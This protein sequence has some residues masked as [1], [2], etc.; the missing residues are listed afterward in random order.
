MA[1]FMDMLNQ[2]LG[3]VT[4]TPLGQLGTQLLM[5][6]GPQ[7]G[8]PSAVNR[9]GQ[10]LGGMGQMQADQQQLAQTQQLRQFQQM[11]MARQ[12]RQMETEDKQRE[13]VQRLAKEDPTFLA[14][15]P[16]ARALLETTGDTG[17]AAELAKLNPQ[18]KQPNMKQTYDQ[19]NPDGTVTQ[20]VYNY[21]TGRYDA[22]ATYRPTAQQNADI[23]AGRF[24][25]DQEYRPQEFDLKKQNAQTVQAN[26]M[27]NQ[28][29]VEL[30]Q[31][32]EQREQATNLRK[33]NIEY[34]QLRQGYTG[35]TTQIDETIADADR[36]LNHP[37]F[38]SLFGPNGMVSAVPGTQ[39]ADAKALYD[40]FVSKI[41]FSE[42]QRLKQMGISLTPTS[43][44]DV[45]NAQKSAASIARSQS[46][47]GARESL[48]VFK[49]K[50][51]KARDE[52]TANYDRM[53]SLYG[54][55]QQ[56]QAPQQPVQIND[57]AGY[58]NLPS[59]ATFI[60]PDGSLRRK[61]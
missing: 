43:N 29:K 22:G 39:A 16:M 4:G 60:A 55:P 15:N 18:A 46:D 12:M 13:A 19:Y 27:A 36:L 47:A 33:N 53:A 8:N 30:A 45:E 52:A 28:A 10:A 50:M 40:Q 37:G 2:G 24:Q 58:D 26:A 5:A 54:S 61:P 31:T 23:N 7:Q 34:E 41:G 57:D 49:T 21:D 35:A 56:R 25:M 6:S 14:N 38:N 1:G 51:Q 44:V 42:L 3:N 20:H 59:G 48:N 17:M 11:Q 9:L 32:K